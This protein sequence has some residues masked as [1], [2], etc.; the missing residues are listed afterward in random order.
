VAHNK[1]LDSCGFVISH[2]KFAILLSNSPPG[3][4]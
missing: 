3:D 2:V 4:F 1:L